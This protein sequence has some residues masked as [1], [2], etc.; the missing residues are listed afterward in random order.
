MHTVTALPTPAAMPCSCEEIGC[1]LG[2]GGD[3]LAE[4]LP[5]GGGS[6]EEG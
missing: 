3:R 6:I 2:G 1:F 4:G 5:G